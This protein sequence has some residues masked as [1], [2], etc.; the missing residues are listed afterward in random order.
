[1]KANGRMKCLWIL[2]TAVI[3]MFLTVCFGAKADDLVIPLVSADENGGMRGI[4]SDGLIPWGKGFLSFEIILVSGSRQYSNGVTA[5]ISYTDKDGR[6]AQDVLGWNLVL[7][8]RRD[9]PVQCD[10]FYVFPDGTQA[11]YTNPQPADFSESLESCAIKPILAEGVSPE[12]FPAL[13]GSLSGMGAHSADRV[14]M[15]TGTVS[16]GSRRVTFQYPAECELVE[17]GS[18][19]TIVRLN[20]NEYVTLMI[21]GG[22][23]SGTAAVHEMMGAVEEV[24]ELSDSMNV[25]AVHGDLNHRMPYLDVVEIGINTADGTGIVACAYA[26]YGNTQIYD[27]LLTVL[28]SIT[29]PEPLEKWLNEVWIPE[30]SG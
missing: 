21:P 10:L 29:D 8:D 18:P 11:N 27:L 7:N 16:R 2:S 3:L 15:S 12:P 30:V 28:R 25:S 9:C 17:E 20:E 23:L 26:M 24:R 5:S 14:R 22:N 6:A 19:G 4:R 13:T 1:M